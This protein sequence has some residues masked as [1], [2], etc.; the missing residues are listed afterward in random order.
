M[1]AIESQSPDANITDATDAVWYVYVTITTVGYGDQYPV[2]DLGRVIGVVIMTLGVGLFGTIT[3]FLANA[4][5]GS[6]DD[7]PAELAGTPAEPAD[8]MAQIKQ[9]K[10]LLVAYEKTSTDMRDKLDSLETMLMEQNEV[11]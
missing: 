7:E 10:E 3:A 5:V 4:F 6:G 8:M 1:L 2:T 11:K 9:I